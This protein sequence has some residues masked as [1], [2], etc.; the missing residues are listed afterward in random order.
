M[1]YQIEEMHPKDWEQVQAIY[2]EGIRTGN[3]TFETD[4]PAWENWDKGHIKSPRLVARSTDG[5]I[6]GWAALSPY[7]GRHVYRGVAELGI[8]IG[9]DYRG[10]GVGSGLLTALIEK[11][12]QAGFWTLQAGILKEN[13][14]SRQLHAKAGFR[15]VGY[16]EKIGKLNGEW[17]DVILMERRSLVAENE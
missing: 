1:S 16:R 5:K 13:I 6:M 15:E 11:A 7:S 9:Q 10:Q 2:L 12:E 8:Y 4:A 3:A 14:A 17:R